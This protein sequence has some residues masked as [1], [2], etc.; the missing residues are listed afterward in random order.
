MRLVCFHHN[1]DGPSFSLT[2]VPGR[3]RCQR[4]FV[5]KWAVGGQEPPTDWKQVVH[6]VS[7]AVVDKPVDD[8]PFALL[9]HLFGDI[10]AFVIAH[11]LMA[12]DPQ[13]PR[14]IHF[15]VRASPGPTDLCERNGLSGGLKKWNC[16]MWPTD[17]H[18]ACQSC[19]TG[20]LLGHVRKSPSS[21]CTPLLVSIS[22]IG[23]L[24]VTTVPCSRWS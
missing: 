2:L 12:L 13:R 5:W 17:G 3:K 18:D 20:S 24:F 14:P 4:L 16:S 22:L 10:L 15:S 19:R 21:T 23:D 7:A 8:V 11:S 6:E 1:G 9:G